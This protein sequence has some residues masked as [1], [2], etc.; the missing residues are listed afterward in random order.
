MALAVIVMTNPLK[1]HILRYRPLE[2][3]DSIR[4]LLVMSGKADL[5]FTFQEDRLGDIAH[6]HAYKPL[7]Y[8]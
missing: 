7:S 6:K 3:G 8:E 5:T 2:Y 4:L 1:H